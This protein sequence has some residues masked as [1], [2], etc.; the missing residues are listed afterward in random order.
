MTQVAL[1]RRKAAGGKKPAP[2]AVPSSTLSRTL[3]SITTLVAIML[4]TFVAEIVL[5]GPVRHAREQQVR[6]DEFRVQLASATAPTGQLDF[7]GKPVEPGSPVAVL[8]IP[9]LGLKE[10][11]LEGT[12]SGVLMSGIGHRRDTPLPGQPGV[13]IVMGRQSAYG[14][15]FAH[16][17]QLPDGAQIAVTTAQGSSMYEVVETRMAGDQALAP[18]A[19]AAQ[20]TLMT[21]SGRPYLAESVLRVDAQ[22]ITAP[23]PAPGRPF[24]AGSLSAAEQPLAGDTGVL[25][26]LLL[27]SQ[28]LLLL[29]GLLAW[30]R[31]IWTFW[32]TWIVAVPVLGAVGLQVSHLLAQ[33]LP[34]LL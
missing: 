17:D 16:L 8:A 9:S 30:V 14:G 1:P 20:L 13:A 25:L 32:P 24:G 18:E 11:V 33:L 10:V 31:S 34:N 29:S 6:Y 5:I 7:E 4:L 2:P 12:T 28:L 26:P 27:W 15:P 22:L 19:D 3:S 23:F 21:A